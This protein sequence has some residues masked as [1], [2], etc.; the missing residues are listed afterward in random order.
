MMANAEEMRAK[1]GTLHIRTV[2]GRPVE[3]I[4]EIAR[5]LPRGAL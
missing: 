1:G 2:T 5:G 4:A 3:N